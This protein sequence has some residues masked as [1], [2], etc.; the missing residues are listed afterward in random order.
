[1]RRA[2]HHQFGI[3]PL[4]TLAFEEIPQ[5]R[6]VAQPGYLVVQI[7]HPVIDQ[8]GDHKALPVLQFELGFSLART[9]RGH[10]E[11][12]NRQRIGEIQSADRRRHFQMDISIGHDHR[13]KFQLALRIP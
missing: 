5:N 7:G 1:M 6:D 10:G 3:G 12:R 13:G 11:S 4:R 8:S 9:Q 2:Q